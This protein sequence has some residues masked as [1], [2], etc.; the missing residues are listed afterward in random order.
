MGD[1]KIKKSKTF[2]LFAIPSFA[3]GV[4]SAFNLFPDVSVINDSTSSDKADI[5]AMKA[6]FEMAGKDLR[7]SMYEWEKE[8]TK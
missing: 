4:A 3:S 1:Y 7:E 8:F 2:R 5:K 6:D